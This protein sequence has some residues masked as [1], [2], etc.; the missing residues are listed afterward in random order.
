[1]RIDRVVWSRDRAADGKYTDRLPTHY[2][3]EVGTTPGKWT[4]VATGDD[5]LP[6]GAKPDRVADSRSVRRFPKA[7]ARAV[8]N[9]RARVAN[10]RRELAELHKQPPMVY[11][12]KFAKPEPTYRFHRGDPMQHARADRA[13]GAREVRCDARALSPDAA[14]ARTPARAGEVDRRS[15]ESADGAGDRQS[16]LAAPFRPRTRR[17]A[18][19]LRPQRRAADASGTAR[20]AGRGADRARLEPEADSSA[21]RDERDVPADSHEAE[22]ARRC[23]IVGS[24]LGPSRRSMPTIVYLWRYPP[25]RLE[26]EPLRDA[27]LPWPASSNLKRGGP[28][29]DLFEPNDNYVRVYEPK[30]DVRPGRVAADDLPG[31]AADAA[32]RRVRRVRLPRRRADRPEAASARRRRCRRSTCS[33]ARS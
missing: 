28:G 23:K 15:E 24:E 7:I 19:R 8:A 26:A 30:H 2:T 18:E 32:R 3:I 29:F 17:H 31:K 20:L 16:A 25:R 11:A 13:G 27:I 22:D 9:W 12:G 21:D 5:R 4:T 1:M 6:Y 14:G 10:S 33:T